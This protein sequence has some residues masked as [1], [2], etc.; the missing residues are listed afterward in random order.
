[1]LRTLRAYVA[2]V[3]SSPEEAP[4]G[5]GPSMHGALR[6]AWGHSETFGHAEIEPEHLVLGV[7]DERRGGAA[8]ALRH[9]RVDVRATKRDIIQRLRP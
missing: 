1:M 2:Q 3:G 6:R 4:H 7:I 5:H 9:L 8:R